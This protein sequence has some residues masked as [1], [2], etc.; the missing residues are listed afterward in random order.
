MDVMGVM[1]RK[2][3]AFRRSE[4]PV[5]MDTNRKDSDA[6]A[7]EGARRGRACR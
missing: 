6:Q 3:G 5:A 1:K 2:N 7:P 4:S